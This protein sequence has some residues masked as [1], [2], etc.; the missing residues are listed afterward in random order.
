MGTIFCFL[1]MATVVSRGPV[2][3]RKEKKSS[4]DS[5]S[6]WALL[7]DRFNVMA[8][9]S[10]EVIGPIVKAEYMNADKK[11]RLMLKKAKKLLA[12]DE[13]LLDRGMR[14]KISQLLETNAK[15]KII[16][17]LRL[18]LEDIWAQRGN[19]VSEVLASLK[20]WVVKAE[21]TQLR[22]LDEFVQTLS[23]FYM[24]EPNKP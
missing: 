11:V 12:L 19:D 23:T 14:H 21:S 5:E 24:P 13:A 18:E 10:E 9:Y 1:G 7:N 2:V 8:T 16:Y 22:A 4:L 15:I 6:V 20:N 17:D 3:Q